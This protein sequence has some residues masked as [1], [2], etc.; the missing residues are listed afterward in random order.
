MRAVGAA[1]TAAEVSGA[2]FALP[3]LL[4]GR[5]GFA[6]AA[7]LRRVRFATAVSSFAAAALHERAG[8]RTQGLDLGSKPNPDSET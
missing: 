8:R 3:S 7:P 4:R 2:L 1:R 5:L 6:E